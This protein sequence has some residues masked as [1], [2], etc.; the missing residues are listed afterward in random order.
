MEINERETESLK[1]ELSIMKD[2]VSV[3]EEKINGE[4]KMM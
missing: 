4:E 2:Q 1:S 3:L